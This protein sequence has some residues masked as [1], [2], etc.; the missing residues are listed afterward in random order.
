[1]DCE[2]NVSLQTLEDLQRKTQEV[3]DNKLLNKSKSKKFADFTISDDVIEKDLKKIIEDIRLY[4]SLS[5]PNNRN[6]DLEIKQ[7]SQKIA[8]IE[9]ILAES[10]TESEMLKK[11]YFF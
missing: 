5:D 7:I 11:Y 6:L 10:F 3:L 9:R 1:M 4:Q 2:A 8:M